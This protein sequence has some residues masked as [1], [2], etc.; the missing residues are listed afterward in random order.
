[1]PTKAV[2]FDGTETAD[3]T[4]FAD[5]ARS[6]QGTGIVVKDDRALCTH[7]GLL[8]VTG[9]QCVAYDSPN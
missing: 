3:A 5:R 8:R 7:A 6:Y 1:M 2:G 4:D 9:Y